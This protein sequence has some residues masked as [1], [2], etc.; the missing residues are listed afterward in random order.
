MITLDLFV[1]FPIM[2]IYG[3][4][5]VQVGLQDCAAQMGQSRSWS[6]IDGYCFFL[7]KIKPL[8][9]N[10]VGMEAKISTLFAK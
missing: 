8:F 1:L 4:S 10:F 5:H 6:C 3:A 7:G 2:C 9:V